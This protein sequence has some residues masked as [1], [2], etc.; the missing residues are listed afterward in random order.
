MGFR[1]VLCSNLG[2]RV[3]SSLDPAI[4]DGGRPQC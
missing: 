4:A 3:M 2:H 1:R